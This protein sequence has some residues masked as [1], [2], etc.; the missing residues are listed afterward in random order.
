MSQSTAESVPIP[1]PAT[2]W[3]PSTVTE[4]DL[5]RAVEDGCL[6]P[7][8]VISWREDVREDFPT[9]D[10]G[11]I[12][13]FQPFFLFGLGLPAEDLFRGLLHFY[14]IN[15]H[16][17]NPNSILQ[18]AIFIYLCEGYYCIRPHFAFFL[19]LCH[20]KP[21]HRKKNPTVVGGNGIQIWP[22]RNGEFFAL[23]LRSSNKGRWSKWFY[24]SNPIPGLPPFTSDAPMVR[25]CWS[26]LPGREEMDQIRGLLK[27]LKHM[28]KNG[29]TGVGVAANFVPCRIQP[30]KSRSHPVWEYTRKNDETREWQETTH[31]EKAKERLALFFETGT[32]ITTEGCLVLLGTT[33]TDPS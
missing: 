33:L 19:Y 3:T 8:E 31:K 22:D 2:E 21:K 29:L 1:D 9:P 24:C 4:G 16:H 27:G 17:L 25:D 5:E 30:L 12:V 32:V 15:L 26:T 7:Q 23:P 14:G 13:V 18:I 28:I 6:P 10:T 11:K 20:M